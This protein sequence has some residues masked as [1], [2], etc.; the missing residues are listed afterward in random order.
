M[1]RYK[2][3]V[4]CNRIYRM[5]RQ[6]GRCRGVIV[7]AWVRRSCGLDNGKMSQRRMG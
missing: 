2:K 4:I 7:A 6:M 5:H 1:G 3:L